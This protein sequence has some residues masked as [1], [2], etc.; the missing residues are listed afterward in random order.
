ME[1]LTSRSSRLALTCLTLLPAVC[2][3]QQQQPPAAS[4]VATDADCFTSSSVVGAVL[5]TFFATAIVLAV[6]VFLLWWIYYRRLPSSSSNGKSTTATT[7]PDFS[8]GMMQAGIFHNQKHSQ[9]LVL[10]Y[11]L[12]LITNFVYFIHQPSPIAATEL[13]PAGTYFC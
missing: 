1:L 10:I 7:P 4:A 2:R 6:I 3:A 5:G 9:S 11:L 8:D 12:T 13:S